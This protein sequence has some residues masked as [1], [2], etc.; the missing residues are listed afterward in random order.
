MEDNIFDIPLNDSLL[1]MSDFFS[2]G[3]PVLLKSFDQAFSDDVLGEKDAYDNFFLLIQL[4]F[5]LMLMDWEKKDDKSKTQEYFYEKY[6]IK[7]LIKAFDCRKIDIM[8]L[9]DLH[10]TNISNG[11]TNL[12][13]EFMGIECDDNPFI[14][15]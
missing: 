4:F 5:L 15:S 3:N 2:K 9:L 13:I 7:D 8:S 12:G 10:N 1:L 11:T 14:I 6:R